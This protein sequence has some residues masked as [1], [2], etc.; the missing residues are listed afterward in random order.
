MASL[1]ESDKT[2]QE[3]GVIKT[4]SEHN[5]VKTE[6]SSKKTLIGGELEN[7]EENCE[8]RDTKGK[9]D[10][11]GGNEA[12]T[13]YLKLSTQ[14]P[15]DAPMYSVIYYKDLAFL[16]ESLLEIDDIAKMEIRDDDTFVCSFPR[17][18]TTLMQELVY[19]IK[20]LDFEKANTVALDGRFPMLDLLL[21]GQPHFGGLKMIEKKPSPRFVKSHLPHFMLPQQLREGKG[22][23]IYTARNLPDALWSAYQLMGFFGRKLP[24]EKYF[25]RFM[26]GREPWTPWGRH[27]R[28]FWDHK[29]DK[30]ILFL[31]F[32]DTVK[33]MPGAIRKVAKF[34]NEDLT[35]Q[36]IKR[37]CEHCSIENMKMMDIADIAGAEYLHG[38]NLE[39]GKNH[40][41]FVNTGTG[42]GW[43]GQ[44]T[45]EMCAQ[46]KEEMEK[47]L[48]G[49]GL[50]FNTV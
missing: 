27:V 38:T 49:S 36:D 42:G 29:D 34:L 2:I 41:G 9:Q 12:E 22:K 10:V 44:T 32:E 19:A 14:S 28:E 25:K 17:S 33:D 16:R 37:I 15:A 48:A 20:T 3:N 50:T 11:T 47:S 31:K 18:G 4:A 5:D 35:E 1:S 13:P 8:L 30:N 6:E 43:R 7:A 39:L 26:Q 40:G 21:E 24:F 45:D 46:M 23:I